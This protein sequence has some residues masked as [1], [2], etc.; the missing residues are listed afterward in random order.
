MF[1]ELP[2]GFVEMNL[3][4][5][6]NEGNQCD[7]LENQVLKMIVRDF[8]V[9]YSKKRKFKGKPWIQF[10]FYCRSGDQEL[11][12]YNIGIYL[13]TVMDWKGTKED[14]INSYHSVPNGFPKCIQ[15]KLPKEKK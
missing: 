4:L 6:F 10:N 2:S 7:M 13:K 12:A 15:L 1:K 14:I 9:L 8:Y 11:I 5:T 3:Q